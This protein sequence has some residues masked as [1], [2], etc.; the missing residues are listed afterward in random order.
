MLRLAIIGIGWAG[1]RQTQA[2][3]ELGRKVAIECIAD[4]DPMFLRQKAEELGIE[5]TYTDYQDALD[6]PDVEAVSICTPHNFHCPMALKAA[7]AGKHILCEKPIA[8]T[9]ADATRMIEAAEQQGVKLYIAEN[10]SYTPVARFLRQVVETG[11]HIGE[12]TAV[13]VVS[14]FQAKNFGYP[15]RR[16]WLTLPEKGGTGTWMLQGIHTMAQMRYIF[17]EVETVYVREHY[18]SSFQRPDIEGTMSG[19][20]TLVSGVSVSVLH[21]CEV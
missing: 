18:A 11:E 17:G 13:T 3:R 20:L 5:K 2:I 19:L 10:L 8:M 14:G 1:E 7:A 4:S 16:D 6:D 9:V 12:I 21:T 15:G